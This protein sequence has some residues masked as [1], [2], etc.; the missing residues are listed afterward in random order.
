MTDVP[1]SPQPHRGPY[2]DLSDEDLATAYERVAADP[3]D[4]TAA[5]LL[6]ELE[7]RGLATSG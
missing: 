2:A 6:A 5:L 4:A 7:H 3:D 1:D